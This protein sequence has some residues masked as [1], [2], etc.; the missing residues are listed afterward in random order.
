MPTNPVIDVVIREKEAFVP[1][2]AIFAICCCCKETPNLVTKASFSELLGFLLIFSVSCASRRKLHRQIERNGF[3]RE[4]ATDYISMLSL[5]FVKLWWR[6]DYGVGLEICIL[7][8]FH[9]R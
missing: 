2:S 5:R 8:F 7:E 6:N 3:T 9:L 4:W 1:R